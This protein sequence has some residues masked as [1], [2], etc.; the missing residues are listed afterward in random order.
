MDTPENTLLVVLQVVALILTVL[1][2]VGAQQARGRDGVWLWVVAFAIHAVSQALRQLASLHWGH[3]ATLPIG[4]L[5][6]PFGYAVLYIGIRRYFGLLPKTGFALLACL[7]ATLLSIAAVAKD[8]SFA[9]LALTSCVTALFEALTAAVFWSAWKREG[10]LIRIGATVIFAVSAAASLARA[11]SVAPAWNLESSLAPTNT[12]WIL[13]FV[14]LNIL[15]AGCLLFLLNQS[16]LDELQSMADY[17]TLTGLLNRRGLSRRMQQ[18]LALLDADDPA[19]VGVLCMD[20]DHFKSVND[21]YGHGAGDDVL[22]A[23]GKLIQ[24]NSRPSDTPSRPG[25]EEF[26]VVVETDSEVELLALAERMRAAV[27]RAPFPTRAGL[28]AITVSIGAALA[29][30]DN[31]SLEALGERADHSLLQAKRTGRN[32]VVFAGKNTPAPAAG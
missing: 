26:G 16:L 22:R 10:G 31:E 3:H 12:F 11:V 2:F 28:V 20:L 19:S 17:D 27:E 6:G 5:G 14:A 13:V 8:M 18:R 21:T 15:Q 1:M 9:S 23:V 30:G 24:D 25:G 7:L 4:H 29:Q 32:R